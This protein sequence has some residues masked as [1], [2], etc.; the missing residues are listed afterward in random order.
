MTMLVIGLLIGVA[1]GIWGGRLSVTLGESYDQFTF[2][3]REY[4]EDWNK[5]VFDAKRYRQL[6]D[7]IVE[8]GQFDQDETAGFQ[9][10]L[11]YPDLIKSQFII[12]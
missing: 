6:T 11:E 8:T 3:K 12:D 2:L 9:P 10:T 5:L 1:V 4:G 7:A